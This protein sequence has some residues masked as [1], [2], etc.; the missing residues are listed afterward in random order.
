MLQREEGHIVNIT[1][2]I[3]RQPLSNVPASIPILI[4]G[5]LNAVTRGLALEYAAKGIKVNAVAPGIIKTPMHKPEFYEFLNALQPV[6]HMGEVQDVVDAVLHLT[7][8]RFIT[9]T[10]LEVDGG[11][12]SGKW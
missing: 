1:A 8:S 5:G 3:A 7:S 2:S 10:V 11:M 9:G 4:K 6:G 12:A